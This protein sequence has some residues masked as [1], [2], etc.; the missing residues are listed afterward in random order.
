M[1]LMD[2]IKDTM[3]I[4]RKFEL[5]ADIPIEELYEKIKPAMPEAVFGPIELKKGL[6][7]KYIN[8]KG[9][10]RAK[11]TL[12]SK[13]GIAT[14]KRVTDTESHATISVM[15]VGMRVDGE[16]AM[17]ILSNSNAYF[18]AVAEALGNIL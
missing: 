7:G 3:D 16:N 11:V 9:C 6:T 17:D 15:G 14:L 5:G 18:K 4:S 12:S 10:K 8:F 13:K 2:S 1:G